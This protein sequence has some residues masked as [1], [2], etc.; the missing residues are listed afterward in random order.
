MKR[1]AQMEEMKIEAM[2]LRRVS[3]GE[4]DF[5]QYSFLTGV[6]L[7][8]NWARHNDVPSIKVNKDIYLEVD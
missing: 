4:E 1:V 6:I 2:K 5:N 7:A 3:E 8:L